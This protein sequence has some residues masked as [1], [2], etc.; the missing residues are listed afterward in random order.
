M[1]RHIDGKHDKKRWIKQ[2]QG[3]KCPDCLKSF[4]NRQAKAK[5]MWSEHGKVFKYTSIPKK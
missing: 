4:Y 2:K 1:K 5:H 3:Y